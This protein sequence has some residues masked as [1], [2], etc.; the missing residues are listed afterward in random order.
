[1]RKMMSGFL[2]KKRKIKR[3]KVM[4][5]L[6]HLYLIFL[7]VKKSELIKFCLYKNAFYLIFLNIIYKKYF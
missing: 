5:E 1:M 7:I 3:K 6:S 2:N 4:E